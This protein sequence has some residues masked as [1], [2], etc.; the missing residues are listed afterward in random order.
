MKSRRAIGP[1]AHHHEA[2]IRASF[3]GLADAP[4]E[5]RMSRSSPGRYALHDLL[6]TY[7]AELALASDGDAERSAALYRA[8]SHYVH[9]AHPADQLLNPQ[10]D[11]PVA[12]PPVP[13]G[14]GP[15][16]AADQRQALAWFVAEHQVLLAMIRQA[17]VPH[18][19]AA[20]M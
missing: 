4:L 20:V 11:D 13:A 18:R 8:L 2:E 6:R 17:R 5:I 12:P 3:T 7:A 1:A 9:S 15:E 19:R 16:Q 14:V 10:R